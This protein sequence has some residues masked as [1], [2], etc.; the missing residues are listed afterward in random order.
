MEEE[1]KLLNAESY[2]K[3]A[4]SVDET[5]QEAEEALT[6]LRKHMQVI[7]YFLFILILSELI[8]INNK[9]PI[10]SFEQ[11]GLKLVICLTLCFPSPQ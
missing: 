10:K 1:D 7:L 11:R 9:N 5:F 3:K 8:T 4:L 6:K 2:Y